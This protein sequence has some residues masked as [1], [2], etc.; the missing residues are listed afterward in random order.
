ML[1]EFACQVEQFSKSTAKQKAE[2]KA[3]LLS[4]MQETVTVLH[5]EMY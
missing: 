5:R 1:R 2:Q 3:L 4:Q